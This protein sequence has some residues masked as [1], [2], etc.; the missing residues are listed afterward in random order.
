M[1]S[2]KFNARKTI[3]DNIT[4][5]SI[6]EANRYN[7]LKLLVNA[8]LISDLKL[9]PKFELQRAFTDSDGKKIRAINYV[10]DFQYVEDGCDIVE[11]VKG[12]E[13]DVWLLKKKMF[14]YHHSQYELR[15]IDLW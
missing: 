2:H 12:Y 8:G 3:V 4:F 5:A 14:L 1:R 15:I 11:E 13:T 6:A 9:Q 10:A 7:E